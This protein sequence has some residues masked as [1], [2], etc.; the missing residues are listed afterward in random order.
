[1]MAEHVRSVDPDRKPISTFPVKP[2]LSSIDLSAPHWHESE[3]ERESD[4]RVREVAAQWKQAGKPVIVGQH[5]NTGMNWDP[6]SGQRMR[7]RTWTA[8]FQEISLIF[9]NTSWSKAG[10]HR[11]HYS[12]GRDANIYLGPE[13]RGYIRVLQDFSARL[14]AGIRITPVDVSVPTSIRGYGLL[15]GTIAAAYLHHFETH[16][17]AV[18]GA[19][20]TVDLP[21]ATTAGR[22]LVGEWIDPSSGDVIA[23]VQVPPG[24]QTMDVPPFTVD[25]ALLVTSDPNRSVP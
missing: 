2:Y 3:G 11:G 1:L 14:N 21:T 13:E 10:M 6:F 8:L 12:P 9:W 18:Y 15:S 7:I 25:L 19:K 23:R 5:G 22:L 24:R 20:I 4:R 16:A 17:S